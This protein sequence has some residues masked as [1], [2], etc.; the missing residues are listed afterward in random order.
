MSPWVWLLSRS[1]VAYPQGAALLGS[2]DAL[3]S[4]FPTNADEEYAIQGSVQLQ[5]EVGHV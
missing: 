1:H 3:H 5:V 4:S 2:V